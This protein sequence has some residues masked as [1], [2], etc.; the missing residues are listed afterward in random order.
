MFQY[1]AA[2]YLQEKTGL[3]VFLDDFEK[4]G[5]MTDRLLECFELP[6]ASVTRMAIS[7]ILSHE[8]FNQYWKLYRPSKTQ[9]NNSEIAWETFDESFFSINRLTKLRGRFQSPSYFGHDFKFVASLFV[10]KRNHLK[11][12]ES[13]SARLSVNHDRVCAIHVRQADDYR[14][15]SGATAMEGQGWCLPPSYYEKALSE[16]RGIQRYLV[17]GDNLNWSRQHFSG[18]TNVEFVSGNHPVVDMFLI[19]RCRYKILA[20]STFAWWAGVLDQRQDSVTYAP[21]YFLGYHRKSWFPPDIRIP[22]WNYLY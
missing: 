8:R 17:F 4:K 3:P 10:P 1:A 14:N 13:E 7:R 9:V 19:S 22:E 6:E 11:T 12:L 18:L 21:E 16:L 2:K 5:F 15:M 20:N